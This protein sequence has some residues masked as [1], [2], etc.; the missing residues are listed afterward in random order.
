MKK[1]LEFESS[2]K[3]LLV[4]SKKIANIAKK[5]DLFFLQGDLGAGKTTF[6]R[7]LI[8]SIFELEKVS[9]P[10]NIKSPSFP[11]VI[12]YPVKDYT[13]YHYDFYRLNKKED[14]HEIG[15]LED[16]EKN[17][18]IIEWPEI[19]LKNYKF[20]NYFLLEFN[21]IDLKKRLITVFHT[22]KDML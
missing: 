8:N 14:L 11:V 6:A 2:L 3:E 18:S 7:A 16:I 21:I 12:S 22:D 19:I 5:G 9:L 20:S 10:S 1:L 15:I 4:F 17:I 13:I